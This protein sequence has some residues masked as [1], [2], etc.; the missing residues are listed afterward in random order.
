M[1]TFACKATYEL[2]PG[3]SALAP[4]QEELHEAD[5]HWSGDPAWSLYAP[6]DIVPIRP[7]ADIVLVGHAFAP[8]QVPVRSL[9]TRLIVG[10]VDKSIEVFCD[11]SFTHDGVLQEGPRFAKMPLLYER[12]SGAWSRRAT[13]T[14]RPSV[15]CW[16]SAI[17]SAVRSSSSAPRTSAL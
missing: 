5:S 16:S 11:R 14:P 10:D 3:E 6:R 8:N 1:L 9:I 2:R 17:T 7:R 12:A 13:S 15:S 4:Q